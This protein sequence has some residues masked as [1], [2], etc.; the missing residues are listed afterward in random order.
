MNGGFDSKL[1]ALRQV[2]VPSRFVK[3]WYSFIAVFLDAH[4]ILK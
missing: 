2:R 1:K 4:R 3:N